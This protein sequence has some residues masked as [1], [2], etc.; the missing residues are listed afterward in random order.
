MNNQSPQQ[1]NP[2]ELLEVQVQKLTEIAQSQQEQLR[3]LKAQSDKLSALIGAVD[4]LRQDEDD[5]DLDHVKIEDVNMPFMAMVGFLVKVSLAS[6][7]A[8]IILS[9]LGFLL[10]ALFGFLTALIR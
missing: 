1:K 10:F 3:M 8:A 5:D 9:V 4:Q 7:P 2:V 6:I